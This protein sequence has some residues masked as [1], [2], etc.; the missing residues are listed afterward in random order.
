MKRP[1][2]RARTLLMVA[3]VL[4]LQAQCLPW[5]S[6]AGW[7]VTPIPTWRI[8][9]LLMENLRDETYYTTHLAR[10]L[11]FTRTDIVLSLEAL[12]LPL[13]GMLLLA[14]PFMVS[15]LVRGVWRLGLYQL[16]SI[17]LACV[18]LFYLSAVA[19]GPMATPVSGFAGPGC[20]L[21]RVATLLQLI[22]ISRLRNEPD[23]DAQAS[24]AS[25]PR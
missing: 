17:G 13:L 6:T 9:P 18:F 15:W 4:F 11:G 14:S 3:A 25:Q 20:W 12:A 21:V 16:L 1:I 23:H 7:E 22:G 24:Q 10:T 8:W 2:T 19:G 5:Q